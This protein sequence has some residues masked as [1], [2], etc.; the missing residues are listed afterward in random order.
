MKEK[1][2]VLETA[3]NGFAFLWRIWSYTPW[4]FPMFRTRFIT[5]SGDKEVEVAWLSGLHR[6]ADGQVISLPSKKRKLASIIVRRI[7]GR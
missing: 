2:P 7:Q 6:F 1:N 3:E 5:H 4:R